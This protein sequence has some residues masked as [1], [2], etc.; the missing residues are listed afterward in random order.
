MYIETALF[1]S[2]LGCLL[3]LVLFTYLFKFSEQI[4]GG[5]ALI[6]LVVFTCLYLFGI[7]HYKARLFDK[8]LASEQQQQCGQ[9]IQ[10]IRFNYTRKKNFDSAYLF[11]L[12]HSQFIEFSGDTPIL[13][14]LP[15]LE[16]LEPNQDYCFHYS[17][18]VKDWNGRWILT[19]LQLSTNER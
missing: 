8:A 15:E 3:I 16:Y 18:H 14:H 12:Q 7:D 11:K 2:G 19:E 13:K 17:R 5:L 1:F 10:Q 6:I 4:S 9:F